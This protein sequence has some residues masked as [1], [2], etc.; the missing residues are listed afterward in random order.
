MINAGAGADAWWRDLPLLWRGGR[1]RFPPDS[2]RESVRSIHISL[3][4][5]RGDIRPDVP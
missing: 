1:H 2:I 5:E 4:P 3:W